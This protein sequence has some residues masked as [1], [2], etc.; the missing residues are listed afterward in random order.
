MFG[1]H[2]YQL[3]IR[4]DEW[5]EFERVSDN[6]I[7]HRPNCAAAELFHAFYQRKIENI[8]LYPLV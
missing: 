6:R 2:D 4:Y 5:D 7:E 8:R 3:L 1:E